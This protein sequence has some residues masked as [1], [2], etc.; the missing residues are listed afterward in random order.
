VV[1]FSLTDLDYLAQARELHRR[2]PVVDT[3]ADTV[4]RLLHE[5]ADLAERRAD[6][7]LD[8]P[9]VHE[10]GLAAEFFA[11]FVEPRYGPH[12]LA[13]ALAQLD[14]LLEQF[15]R[16]REAIELARTAAD[17]R[18]IHSCG[19]IAALLA[20]EGAHTLEDEPR[21]L[22][23]F[24]RLGVRLMT[25]TWTNSNEFAGSSGDA[26]RDR[27]LSE[28]GRA[29]VAR[30]NRLGMLVDVSHASDPAFRDVLAVS[31]AP[32]IA[33]HSSCRALCDVP[34]N[35][36][37]EMIRDLA[38]AGGVMHINFY[39][40]FLDQANRDAWAALRPAAYAEG[41]ELYERWKHEPATYFRELRR[42]QAGYLAK[43]PPVTFQRIADHI[44]HAVGVAGVEHVGIGSDFDGAAMPAGMDASQLPCLTAE[45]LRRGFS[46]DNL[47]KI[48]GGNVLRLMGQVESVMED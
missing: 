9:R 18:R 8:L 48:L 16:H 40:A 23:V 29:L 32:V 11:I 6:A 24:Y 1:S 25:I 20:I 26:G 35:L 5:N 14:L 39:P 36:S 28:S 38:R 10:G 21:A 46:E 37:D 31:K 43:L 30:M 4:Q 12:F 19:R 3:H 27:G 22:D 34:R 33:S 7:H 2:I 17:V 41:A 13:C 47:E 15:E 45:L 44:E 42:L